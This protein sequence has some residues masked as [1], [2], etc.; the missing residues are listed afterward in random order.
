MLDPVTA[1]LLK[2]AA[3]TL[4]LAVILV[5]LCLFLKRRLLTPTPKLSTRAKWL[6]AALTIL[7]PLCQLYLIRP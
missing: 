5:S 6:L 4:I 3:A 1:D 2:A 7:L